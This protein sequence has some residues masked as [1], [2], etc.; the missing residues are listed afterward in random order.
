MTGRRTILFSLIALT[1]G[2]G[3]GAQAQ[4]A[5]PKADVVFSNGGRILTM[6]ADGTERKVL[7]GKDRLPRNDGLGAV[8]PSVSPD[9]TKITFGFRRLDRYDSLFDVW[10]MNFDGTGARKLLASNRKQRYADPEFTAGG[11]IIAASFRENSSRADARIFTMDTNGKSRKVM[12]RL[13]QRQRPW[14]GWKSLAEPSLSPDGKHLLYLLDPGYDGTSFEEGYGASL[15]V[16]NIDTGKSRE[17]AGNSLGGDFSPGGNRIVFSEVDSEG[18]ND[19]CWSYDYSCINFSRIRLV[20]LNGT[21]ARD[22]TSLDRRA[23]DE[24]RPDWSAPG[25][26]VFQSTRGP[27]REVAE[28]TE[29]WSIRPGGEC[30][31]RLTNGSPA[32]LSPVLVDPEGKLTG[33]R[34]CN[35]RPPGP[36]RELTAPDMSGSAIDNLWLGRS[37]HNVLLSNVEAERNRST[38]TYADCGVIPFSGCGR[39]VLIY[40]EDI[41]SLQGYTA[42]YIGSDWAQKQRGIPVLR[43]LKP[44]RETPAFTAGFT[45]RT[46]FFII[47]GSGLGDR[48][49]Q[50]RKE[51]DA[52]RA[53]GSPLT[54]GDLPKPR[55]PVSDIRAMKRVQRVYKRTGSVA[56]TA[57]LLDRGSYFVRSN[58]KFAR[59]FKAG[60]YGRINCPGAD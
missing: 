40:N 25:R 46:A 10:V 20:N 37:H 28:T 59:I 51:I 9:G 4:A 1:M 27:E 42:A 29:I 17:I 12:L 45:G 49:L 19:F 60:G 50:H 58:L 32:S 13:K 14:E 6:K 30:L 7:F 56:R 55:I 38:F 21:G 18:D 26:I 15:R 43:S 33:P 54:T 44:G 52:L 36:N 47:G 8:E 41:C 53:V 39:G 5:K 11:R 35:A 48:K 16:L 22:L 34:G 31:A 2:L 24:R 23:A 3:L 57:R